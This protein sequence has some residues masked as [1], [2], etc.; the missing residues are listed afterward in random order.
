MKKILLT[1]LLLL[2][3]GY[4]AQ[5]AEKFTD[6]L[7]S[8]DFTGMSY[9]TSKTHESANGVNYLAQAA[10]N[11]GFQLRTSK[12]GTGIKNTSIP[13][14]YI[15]KSV[16]V[17][18]GTTGGGVSIYAGEEELN[19]SSLSNEI[20]TSGSN[21]TAT[22]EVNAKYF[23]I[24]ATT[25][26]YCVISD[27]TI[28]YES[29]AV[30]TRQ[31][32]VL[33]WSSD[34][35]HLHLG[36]VFE[37]PLLSATVDGQESAEALA[38][39]KYSSSNE[40]IISVAEDGTMTFSD[41]ENN[42]DGLAIITATIP[43]DNPDFKCQGPATFIIHI[44]DPDNS[45]EE[46]VMADMGYINQEVV[47]EIAGN[48]V[49]ISIDDTNSGNEP[50]YYNSNKDL[51]VYPGSKLTISVIDRFA[52]ESISFANKNVTA[53]LEVDGNNGTLSNNGDRWTSPADKDVN[54]VTFNIT[55]ASGNRSWTKI[56]VNYKHLSRIA[57]FEHNLIGGNTSVTM[58][59][60]LYIVH[61]DEDQEYKVTLNVDGMEESATEH[62]VSDYEQPQNSAMRVSP[63][64]NDPVTHVAT[65]VI[66][67]PDVNTTGTPKTHSFKVTISHNGEEL[68]QHAFTDEDL[69]NEHGKE[70]TTSGNTGTTGIEEVA[71]DAAAAAEYFTL[72]GV[73]VA[74]PQAGNIY[75]ARR[76]GKVE[77]QLV[78]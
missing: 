27:I 29:T 25:D 19:L 3:I 32:V 42:I 73:R 77:K 6:E 7:T 48:I 58:H 5:A 71:A 30:D 13:E 38:A 15:I 70:L 34:H 74:E 53:T 51:R 69:K 45:S 61:Y 39:V 10:S 4:V 1:L 55:G 59:Y 36:D 17:S 40:D 47:K 16:E 75:L 24:A 65:G 76:A 37:A 67:I 41:N 28:N 66:S 20:G 54:S 62:F 49:T 35:A 14:N 63:N 9:T 72:Q 50:K 18:M 33:T 2:G 31:A 23:A 43:N 21:K 11:K 64:T 44:M 78:K 56:T 26:T 12:S 46:F 60:S 52:I 68:P 22:F 8:S 57:G